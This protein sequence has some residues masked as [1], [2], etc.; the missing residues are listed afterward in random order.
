MPSGR[1]FYVVGA[2]GSG[3]D[4]LLRYGREH[5]CGHGGVVFAHRYITRPVELS[6]E[7]HIALSEAEFEA[8]RD[9]G[10]FAMHWRANG[11][12]YGIGWEIN[13]WLAKGCHVVVN[14]SR[15]YLPRARR[16]YPD[17]CAV[18]VCVA[19]QVLAAR[20][21]ARGRESEEQIAQRLARA[22]AYTLLD[23]ALQVIHNDGELAQAGRQLL[24]LLADSAVAVAA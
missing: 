19:P 18:L 17:L 4:S 7:N 5:L 8:R 15:E 22:Q 13:F 1:L 12:R 23:P 6:G 9:A 24:R 16:E 10:L 11:L 21:R 3:K 20:L 14:G 2:S